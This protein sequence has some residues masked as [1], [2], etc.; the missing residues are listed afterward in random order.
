MDVPVVREVGPPAAHLG[1]LRRW[2]GEHAAAVVCV[3]ALLCFAGNLLSSLPRKS[4]TIDEYVHIPAGVAHLRGDFQPNAEHPPLAKLIAALPLTALGLTPPPVAPAETPN[5]QLADA[6]RYFW[7]LNT[8][9][10][11]AISF[12]ARVPMIA[13]AVALGALI[14]AF[15]RTHFGDR[16]AAFAVALFALEPTLLAHG[17]VVHTDMVAALGLLGVVAAGAWYLRAPTARRAALLG[18]MLGLMLLAKFSMLTLAPV[19]A[20]LWA[21]LWWRAPGRNLG[22]R[23]VVGHAAVSG[24]V[25]LVTV[26]ACY[27]FRRQPLDGSER[28]WIERQS[29]EQAGFFLGGID[30]L[31][32]VLPPRFLFGVYQQ[33]LH[34]QDGHPASLL[35]DYSLHGWWYY[36]PVAYAL[37]TPL[38]LLG[39]C[40]AAIGW[41]LWRVVARRERRWLWAL[42][43]LVCFLAVALTSRI[44]IGIRHLLPLYPFALILAG[45]ALARLWCAGGRWV[46]GRLV[47]AGLIGWL[48]IESALAY[49]DYVPYM[50]QVARLEPEWALLSDSN[51]EWGDDLGALAHYL[52]DRGET[53]VVG[54]VL[55][56]RDLLAFHGIDYVDY[57]SAEARERLATARYVAIGASF[58][59]GSTVPLDDGQFRPNYFAAYRGRTPEA[60][61]GG[62]IYVFRN[63][64]TPL[65][66]DAPLPDG[67]FRAA[68]RVRQ[69][70]AT[71]RAGQSALVR[72]DIRNESDTLWYPP[73]EGRVLH[74]I[75]LGNYWLDATG[76]ARVADDARA[77]LPYALAPGDALWLHL[78]ITAPTEPGEYW[79]GVDLVQEGVSWFGDRGSSPARSRVTVEP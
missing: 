68:I 61:L 38:P 21:I 46:P 26:N 17:R 70:P 65:L 15:A 19:I 45:A 7:Q 5:K 62:S 34:N 37:K 2:L 24:V 8:G 25:A 20:L 79:L 76:E 11:D 60:I 59:N 4:L 53:E 30:T 40:L 72:V 39:L 78:L 63:E 32:W 31:G 55:G 42:G 28:A 49:P 44:N 14:F 13:V 50:N 58:L 29:G 16:A 23:G 71:L 48:A 27:G 67:A 41:A 33:Y 66:L 9:R 77:P 18:L 22:R 1:S 73:P 6:A 57:L 36:F 3:V 35:G 75:R 74:Q 12:W 51:V 43:P 56:G 10:F 47:V 69:V 64:P 54:A 52:H